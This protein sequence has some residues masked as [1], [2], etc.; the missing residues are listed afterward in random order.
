METWIRGIER[1]VGLTR[2]QGLQFG[3]DLSCEGENTR[4]RRMQGQERTQKVKTN[5]KVD[6]GNESQTSKM[7]DST[8][9]Q[10][11]V[12]QSDG[13]E[14]HTKRRDEKVGPIIACL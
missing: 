3:R 6:V 11:V 5:T 10:I 2:Q 9:G 1:R 12:R 7:N 8:G 13:E 4:S 14:K